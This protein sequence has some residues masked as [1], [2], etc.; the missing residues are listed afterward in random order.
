MRPVGRDRI[1]LPDLGMVFAM[2]QDAATDGDRAYPVRSGRQRSNHFNL[3]LGIP[4]N[5]LLLTKV[6]VFHP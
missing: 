1:C 4:H 6:N 3:N 2:K 5:D